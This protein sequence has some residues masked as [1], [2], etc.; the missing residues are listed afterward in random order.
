MI[1]KWERAKALVKE[2]LSNTE[3]QATLKAEY[4]GG[5]TSAKL[6]EWRQSDLN[7]ITSA[8]RQALVAEKRV[9]LREMLA[10]GKSGY[11]CQ[12]ACRERFGSGVGYE[13]IQ[14]IQADLKANPPGAI[15]PVELPTDIYDGNIHD[16]EA[17]LNHDDP[18]DLL[19]EAP[20]ETS[21]MAV[22]VPP[23]INGTLTHL[24]AIQ[25]WMGE[26]R[27]ESMTL[28]RD[29]RLTML[30]QHEFHLGGAE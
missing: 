13:M 28:T 1:E 27:A 7:R 25:R 20:P 30:V 22:V 18:E 23:K 10:E 24:Q 14:E 4:G 15:Q 3:I 9:L 21:E 2:G 19:V 8:Q 29:G 17:E 6:A 5:V 26:I 16:G 12:Q 11:A